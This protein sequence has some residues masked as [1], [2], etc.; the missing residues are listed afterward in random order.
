MGDYNTVSKFVFLANLYQ[1]LDSNATRLC[2]KTSLDREFRLNLT[3]FTFKLT[4]DII[5]KTQGSQEFLFPILMWSE[6]MI[7]LTWGPA[8]S[9]VL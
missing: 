2:Y 7:V 6:N 8:C 3:F 5:W 9:G 1:V 4:Y